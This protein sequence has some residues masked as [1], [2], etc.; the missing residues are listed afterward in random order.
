[1]STTAPDHR[2]DTRSLRPRR[3]RWVV[4]ALLLLPTL[5]LGGLLVSLHD[6]GRQLDRVTVALVNEDEPVEV[7][8]QLTPLGR[9]LTADLAGSDDPSI[10]WVLSNREDAAEGLESGEYGSVVTIPEDFSADATSVAS[11]DPAQVRQAAI[12]VVVAPDTPVVDVAITTEIYE[13]ARDSLS[14]MVTT[15]F[16]DNIYLSF[17]TMHD[18]LGEAADGSSALADG[19]AQLRDGTV[20]AR[21]GTGQ[22]AA[23]LPQLADGAGAL[24]LGAGELG[25]GATE[26]RSGLGELHAGAGELAGGLG[27]MSRQTAELP[28]QA[29]ALAEGSAQVAD[30]TQQLADLVAPLNAAGDHLTS[31]PELSPAVAELRGLAER[32]GAGPVCGEMH[33]FADRLEEQTS[34]VDHSTASA[35][36]DLSSIAGD[37]ALLNDGARQVADGNAQLADASVEL[38]TGIG[39]AADGATQLEAGLG[40]AR[41]GTGELAAGAGE[42]AGGARELGE[43]SREAADGAREL[44]QGLIA[45]SDG[46]DTAA[47][48]SR[49]LADGL[50]DALDQIPTFT[51]DE[52]RSM[53]TAAADPVLTSGSGSG[54]VTPLAALVA[55]LVLWFAATLSAMFLRPRHGGAIEST[56]PT[57]RIAT[58]GL[59]TWAANVAG[60][61]VVVTVALGLAV[62]PPLAA[63]PL[64]LLVAVLATAAFALIARALVSLWPRA[65]LIVMLGGLVVAAISG[66]TSAA[67]GIVGSLGAV[68]PVRPATTALLAATDADPGGAVQAAIPLLVWLLAAGLALWL[69]AERAR[70]TSTARLLRRAD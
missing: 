6:P 69:V 62:R 46:S 36:Q 50:G 64:I 34:A 4:V 40:E 38:V 63:V 29:R 3:G 21:A 10:D 67:P 14:T 9:L 66:A 43:A 24:S 23:G 1:M 56:E 26:L 60:Q 53:S 7:E 32:C 58:R 41:A 18:Q 57:W 16:L 22:L 33:A 47:D 20:E 54:Y 48:G 30:G 27:E 51:D 11:T 55:A 8:G 5:L 25:A 31:A 39:A 49:E 70:G 61:A 59:G 12:D 42:L 2:D 15:T 37:I 65:G 19:T 45:L 13:A 35:R 52:R 68:L 28:G 44:D 17:D